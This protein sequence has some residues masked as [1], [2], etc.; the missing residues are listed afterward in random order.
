MQ[1]EFEHRNL[2]DFERCD[3][4]YGKPYPGRIPGQ[5]LLNVLYHYGKPGTL[6]VDPM[7]GSGTTVDACRKLG[8]EVAAFDIRPVRPEIRRADILQGI[9]LPGDCAELVFL[10]PPYWDMKRGCYSSEKTDLSQLSYDRFRDALRIMRDES[11]RLLRGGGV[12][13]VLISSR[14]KK[15]QY[16]DL[17]FD[18][19]SVF[20]EKFTSIERICVPYHHAYSES[21]GE[22][23]SWQAPGKMLR[24]FRDLMIFAKSGN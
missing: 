2:W 8:L 6:V 1:I 10:D 9:P 4:S 19:F 11:Y 23:S 22:W 24:A 13:A 14:R 3:P 15:G 12:C 17:A 18:A 21:T 20:R 5:I 16:F 7:A